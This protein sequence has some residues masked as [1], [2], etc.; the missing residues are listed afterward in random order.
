MQKPLLSIIIVNYNTKDDCIKCIQSIYDRILTIPYEVL[1]CDNGSSD[2]SIGAINREFPWVHT[3]DNKQNLGFGSANNIGAAHAK[4]DILFFLNPDTVIDHGIEQM[5]SYMIEQKDIGLI[6]PVVLDQNNSR[7]L[8][9]P[10][11]YSNIFL[12]LTDL[13][14]TPV[15]RLCSTWKKLVYNRNIGRKIIFDTKYIIGCAMMF[16]RSAFDAVGGFDRD[17]F[18]Y[19]EEFDVGRRLRKNG[20]SIQIVPHAAIIHFGGHSTNQIPS[21]RILAI[22]TQSFKR[23]L[24][25]HFPH[26]WHCRYTIE[27]LTHIRQALSACSKIIIDFIFRKDSAMNYQHLHSHINQFKIMR[28]IVKEKD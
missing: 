17:I 8:F 19:G 9:Y 3:I 11:V 2:G 1:V 14:L 7:N 5:C 23:L 6:G 22:G 26:T 24:K 16:K 12:Q 18:M 4:A 13:V 20:Y 28:R 10:P 15:A 25:K 21:D 27:A